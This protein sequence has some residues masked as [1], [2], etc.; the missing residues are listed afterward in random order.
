MDLEGATKSDSYKPLCNYQLKTIS[1]VNRKISKQDR[2]KVYII[3]K[4]KFSYGVQYVPQNQ[5]KKQ[6]WK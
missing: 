3:V 5:W 6:D 2:G 1:H 4:P